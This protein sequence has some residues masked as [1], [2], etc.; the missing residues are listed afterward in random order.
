MSGNAFAS[1]NLRS[2]LLLGAASIATLGMPAMALAQD[3]SGGE[4]V[5]VTGSRIPQQGLYSTSPVSSIGQQEFKL[6]GS[7]SVGQTLRF[8]AVH[9]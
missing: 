1:R 4:V 6:Q 8:A 2:A 5:V 7:T 9:R 3:T